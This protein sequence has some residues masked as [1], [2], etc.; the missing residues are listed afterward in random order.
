MST[1]NKQIRSKHPYLK[2]WIIQSVPS[3]T[4]KFYSMQTKIYWIIHGLVD[5][6]KCQNPNCSN[7]FK[8]RN[9]GSIL[10]G[11][12]RHCSNNCGLN[13]PLT[14]EHAKTYMH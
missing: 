14:K 2:Q 9:V 8:N 13:N 12:P 7:T 4:D 10:K 3:L 1:I 6:P 11:Y 5:F